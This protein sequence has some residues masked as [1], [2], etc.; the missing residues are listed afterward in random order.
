M[1][2]KPDKPTVQAAEKAKPIKAV[3]AA[4]DKA[5]A[6]RGSEIVKTDTKAKADPKKDTKA[7][8]GEKSAKADRKAKPEPRDE[9]RIWVQ[10][11]GGAF[12]GDLPK[13]WAAVKSKAPA[14]AKRDG[15]ATPLRAT[16]RVV[17][18]PFKSEAEAQALVNQLARQGI[19]AFTFTSA[20]GQKVT[21][22]SGK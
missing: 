13:A 4:E 20:A 11:A 21:R 10:V 8:P 14:L 6:K 12:E 1:A 9:P 22:L 16:N 15:Y 3:V 17:T 19:A 7:K 2:A 18:G 5:K